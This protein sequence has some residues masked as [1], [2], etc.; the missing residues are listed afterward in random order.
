MNI[1]ACLLAAAAAGLVVSAPAGAQSESARI[2]DEGMNRSQAMLSASELMD[3]IGARLTGSANLRRAEDWALA[4]MRT[5]GLSNVHRE[6]F[7]FGRGWNLTSSSA[8]MVSPRPLEMTVIPV[9]W[10]PGTNGVL[11]GPVVVAPMS[12]VEHFNEWRGKLAGTIVLV[13]LP[14]ASD[15][16]KDPAFQRLSDKEI[17]EEDAYK[18]PN[19]D[20]DALARRI[21]RASFA[22]QLD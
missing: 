22:K 3:G 14:G 8:R 18:L 17:S 1:K 6:A 12:K 2:I 15:E 4:K 11:R 9:A 19:Y 20:P 13:T 7:D 10:T 5:Y 21:K 16:P